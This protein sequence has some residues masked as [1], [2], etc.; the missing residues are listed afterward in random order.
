[1]F[2]DE[3]AEAFVVFLFHV[4]ELDAAA[5][6]ADV[7]DDGGEVDFVEAGADFQ[8]DGIADA[9]AVRRFDIGAAEADGFYAHA[10]H[11]LGLAAALR[12]QWRLHRNALVTAT[13]AAIS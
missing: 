9:E 13:D 11:H 3:F 2:L 7:A 8:L 12:P 10:A 6:G 1:M 5:V 4:D